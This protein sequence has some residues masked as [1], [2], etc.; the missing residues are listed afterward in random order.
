MP[1]ISQCHGSPRRHTPPGFKTKHL[2]NGSGGHAYPF[3]H[4]YYYI[5]VFGVS[6]G[7]YCLHISSIS[8]FLVANKEFLGMS[9]FTWKIMMTESER[10]VWPNCFAATSSSLGEKLE[11]TRID[12]KEVRRFQQLMKEIWISQCKTPGIWNIQ[13]LYV[14]DVF[15][16]K[17]NISSYAWFAA[18]KP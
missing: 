5:Y 3:H 1:W 12:K 4:F 6:Y 8:L 13:T 2:G 7:V 17:K 15:F 10:P 9:G 16:S 14:K 11:P 18:E